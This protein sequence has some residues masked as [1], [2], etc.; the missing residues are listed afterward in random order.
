MQ[1][2]T[3]LPALILAT[4]V[5]LIAALPRGRENKQNAVGTTGW[6]NTKA[7]T[8]DEV[9]EI[10][11]PTM[12]PE[13][14]VQEVKDTQPVSGEDRTGKDESILQDLKSATSNATSISQAEDPL[15]ALA[16]LWPE[17]L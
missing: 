8:L 2:S 9:A 17:P 11:A 15:S 7:T 16:I 14:W 5:P 6:N 3:L 10:A 13:A 12:K 1:F 4:V